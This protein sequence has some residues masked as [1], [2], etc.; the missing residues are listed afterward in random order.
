MKVT[1]RTAKTLEQAINEAINLRSSKLDVVSVPLLSQ[2]TILDSVASAAA[3]WMDSFEE[4]ERLYEAKAVIRT[5]VGHANN[6]CTN[7]EGRT[8]N[9]L[10]AEMALLNKLIPSL[11]KVLHGSINCTDTVESLTLSIK[12][13]DSA[14]EAGSYY[15]KVTTLIGNANV[16][17]TSQ[18]SK[19]HKQLSLR[20]R[21]FKDELSALNA[22]TKIE[23]PTSVEQTLLEFDI[24]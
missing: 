15:Q 14:R 24:L 22:A 6:T 3:D 12:E 20:L 18:F 19:K 11:A 23:L 2:Q 16:I 17:D 4:V 21:G 8:V 1:L 9:S 7:E 10:L 5:L 13:Q